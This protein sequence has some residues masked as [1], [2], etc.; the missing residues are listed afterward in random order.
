MFY[1]IAG[2]AVFLSLVVGF[3]TTLWLD[4]RCDD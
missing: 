1:L 3:C 2:I 4:K